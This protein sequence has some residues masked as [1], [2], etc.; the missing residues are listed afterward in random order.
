MGSA[1]AFLL[2][3]VQKY[4]GRA[5][6]IAVI[7]AIVTG[8]GFYIRHKIDKGGYDRAVAEY[9]KR[10]A[11]TARQSAEL[12]KLKQHE[13]DQINKSNQERL[14]NATKIYAERYA[15]ISSNPV[16]ERVFIR[17]KA[18]S[19]NSDT[20]PGAGQG[21]SETKEGIARS[22]AAELPTANTRKLDETIRLIETTQA[23]CELLLNQME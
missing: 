8:S 6:A 18:T 9:Q 12:M 11:D 10:D 1:I 23:K 5:A 3:Y 22:F 2:P 15:H 4:A 14:L 20:V 13:S 16:I 17:S 7:L 19:C 21:R